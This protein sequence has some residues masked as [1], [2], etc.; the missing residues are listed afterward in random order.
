MHAAIEMK[1]ILDIATHGVCVRYSGKLH[2]M[3]GVYM[4]VAPSSFNEY[5]R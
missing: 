2:S 1:I 5:L 3:N 4:Y